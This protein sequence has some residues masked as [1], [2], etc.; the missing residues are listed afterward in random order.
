MLKKIKKKFKNVAG[1]MPSNCIDAVIKTLH[2]G[3]NNNRIIKGWVG[4]SLDNGFIG[5]S[6]SLPKKIDS[7][8]VSVEIVSIGQILQKKV[9]I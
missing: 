5:F 3:V 2:L 7:D 8:S 6:F 9:L 4:Y 1:I